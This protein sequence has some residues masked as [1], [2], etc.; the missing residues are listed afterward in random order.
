MED[1]IQ[2]AKEIVKKR[3]NGDSPT[4]REPLSNSVPKY[5]TAGLE[6]TKMA[7]GENK[8]WVVFAGIMR[9]GLDADDVNE[10]IKEVKE[11]YDL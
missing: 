6:N 3:D 1:S 10:H 5:I 2:E 8:Q 4:D 7:T 11:E 9:A